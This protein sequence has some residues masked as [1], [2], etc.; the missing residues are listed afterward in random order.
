MGKL[1]DGVTYSH[2]RKSFV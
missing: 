1:V 2:Q